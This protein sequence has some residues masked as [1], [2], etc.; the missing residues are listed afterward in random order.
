MPKHIPDNSQLKC[1]KDEEAN[2]FVTT[3][4]AKEGEQVNIEVEE[5]NED[6]EKSTNTYSGNV[7]SEGKAVLTKIVKHK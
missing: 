1:D 2:V 3:R 6:G 5:L 7:D 4:N